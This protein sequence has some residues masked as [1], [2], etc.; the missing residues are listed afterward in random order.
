MRINKL[1][2]LGISSLFLL[3]SC[4]GGTANS[5]ASSGGGLFPGIGTSSAQQQENSSQGGGI[6]PGFSVSQITE[7]TQQTQESKQD[8]VVSWTSPVQ[9]STYSQPVSYGV[10]GKKF[11]FGGCYTYING[12]YGT[13]DT[14]SQVNAVYSGLTL[15]FRADGYCIYTMTSQSAVMY[16]SYSQSGSQVTIVAIAGYV[17]GQYS[18]LSSQG[19]S[20][21]Y[22]YDSG[23]NVLVQTQSYNETTYVMQYLY[24]GA[25][26]TDPIAISTV[27]QYSEPV[28]SQPTHSEPVS[29]GVTGK[30]FTYGGCYT[31]I[32]GNYGTD[33]ICSQVNAAYSGMSFDFRSD[34]YCIL[35]SSAATVY[36]TYS[37]SSNQ[38]TIYPQVS[39]AQGQ[40]VDISG[41]GSAT[42]YYDSANN[43]LLTTEVYNNT[44]YV[45]QY[46]YSGPA[47]TYVINL[48][49]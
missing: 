21:T 19:L 30:K 3:A 27:S 10:T 43:C 6:L 29:S 24:Y 45:M 1:L 22:S 12:Y 32:N 41:Q 47:S 25:A 38:V 2:L 42:F 23:N 20:E 5:S 11:Y 13:D 37:Q 39:Y 31:Y 28:Y 14:C 44:T 35:V 16:C 8:S 7:Q 9:E 40:Y 34:G 26:S 48:S 4:G 46:P 33:D 15:D 18:D 36:C 17:A 49:E